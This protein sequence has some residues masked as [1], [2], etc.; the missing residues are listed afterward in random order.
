MLKPQSNVSNAGL[1]NQVL[2]FAMAL[3]RR[4]ARDRDGHDDFA[5]WGA[6]LIVHGAEANAFNDAGIRQPLKGAP[7]FGRFRLKPSH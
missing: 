7:N 6:G 5:F 4:A 2:D 1:L 3:L